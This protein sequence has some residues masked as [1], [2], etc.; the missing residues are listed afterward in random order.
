MDWTDYL[1]SG[2]SAGLLWTWQRTHRF[3]KML[4]SSWV[5]ANLAASRERH[6]FME[7]VHTTYKTWRFHGCVHTVVLRIVTPCSLVSVCTNVSEKCT[8]S[9][10]SVAWRGCSIFFGNIGTQVSHYIAPEYRM[11]QYDNMQL[12]MLLNGGVSV[13]KSLGANGLRKCM[14]LAYIE[15]RTGHLHFH[16][17][18]QYLWSSGQSS[19]PQIQRSGFD[20]RHYPISCKVV[21]LERGP[22]S[23]V[24]TNEELL[25]IK[26]RGSGLESREYGRRD[27]SLWPRDLYPQS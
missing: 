14:Q 1:G 27:P 16:E 26:R 17:H 25:G 5:A 3:H 20:S 7:M 8:A 9:I 4:R 19:W 23:L 21:G 13:R 22:L 12:A 24:S 11:Q 6:S 2:N 15:R 18:V 10:S